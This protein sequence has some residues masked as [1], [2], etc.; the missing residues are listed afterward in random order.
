M[1][2]T[3]IQSVLLGSVLSFGTSCTGNFDEVN[4]NPTLVSAENL[5]PNML[6]TWSLKNSVFA[7]FGPNTPWAIKEYA[8]YVAYEETGDLFLPCDC[9]NPFTYYR[10]FIV[11]LNEMIRLVKDDPRKSNQVA[12]AR[13]WNA[14]LYQ[15][16][17]DSYGD[18]PYSEAAKD[19]TNVINQPAYESQH[20]IYQQLLNELKEASA[21]LSDS[22]DQIT[23]GNQD[24]I[25]QGSAEHWRRFANSLRLR[26]AIR[27]RYADETL[28]RQHVQE[29]INLPLIDDNTYNALLQT[30]PPGGSTPA[31]N[32]N[33]VYTRGQSGNNPIRFG[34]PISEVMIERNDP[35]L[36][37]YATE[38]SD[39]VS[40][41]QGRPIQLEGEEQRNYYDRTNTA[42][43][44]PILKAEVVDIVV[45]NS[46]EVYFLRAE[47]ALAGLSSENAQQM[48]QQGIQQ[49]MAQ[50]G[51]AD[52]AASYIA[53]APVQ[54]GGSE[55]EQLEQIIVQKFIAIY[56]NAFEAWSEWRRTG[57][58]KIWIG[59]MQGATG[60]QIPRRMTYPIDEF[61]KN[62][63]NLRKAIDGLP[64]GDKF[65]SRIWWDKKPGLPY[66]H[67]KQGMFPPN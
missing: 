47:A 15:I 13:I 20:S 17:T 9:S 52:A 56:P 14:F 5:D 34:F 48:Y 10:S 8:G 23:F 1:K 62:E 4:T 36:P 38:A 11:N 58:P 45:M 6:L 50:V 44:G 29:V 24:I 41:Y 53:T 27:V 12:I 51:L 46:A 30:L 42:E 16:M 43:I 33:P 40:G 66:T 7:N 35:R 28:A 61:A 60:G 65:S 31:G 3:I 21:A 63:E 2:R 64:G 55:E 32:V 39:G 19:A 37:I 25:Y 57:Y 22:P 59:D 54:L 26:M 67:P 49:S 18:I